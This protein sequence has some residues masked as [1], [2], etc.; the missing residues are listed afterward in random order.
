MA[1]QV[2][3]QSQRTLRAE[4]GERAAEEAEPVPYQRKTQDPGGLRNHAEKI[5]KSPLRKQGALY[6]RQEEQL[7][8]RPQL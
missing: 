6:L 5:R 3:Q 7:K 8:R 1:G 2:H 4:E